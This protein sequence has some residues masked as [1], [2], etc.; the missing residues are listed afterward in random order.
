MSLLRRIGSIKRSS[1]SMPRR[2]EAHASGQRERGMIRCHI[3][4]LDD[5][6]FTC[7]VH[8]S[9]SNTCGELIA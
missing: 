3:T 8:V 6:V 9:S 4:L 1:Y 5:N 2:V 7:D